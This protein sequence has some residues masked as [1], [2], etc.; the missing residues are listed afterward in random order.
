MALRPVFQ[1]KITLVGSRPPIWRRIQVSDLY[2]FWDL[3]VAIQDAMGWLDSH[4]HLFQIK[5]PVT[6]QLEQFGIPDDFDELGVQPGWDHKIRDY[7]SMSNPKARYDYDFGD[8]WHHRIELEGVFP[9]EKNVRYP[10]CL[11]GQRACPPEDVGGIRGYESFLEILMNPADE[12]YK[13]MLDWVGGDFQPE[14]FD[15]A[16]V[17]FSKPKERLRYAFHAI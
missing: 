15:P 17:H 8:C 1:F 10:I 11:A 3:H 9:K 16:K 2:S 7:F 6:G 13:E 12:E 4:L 14:I 5:D